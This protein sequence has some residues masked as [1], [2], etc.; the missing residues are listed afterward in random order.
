MKNIRFSRREFL[1]FS[2]ITLSGLALSGTPFSLLKGGTS[3]VAFAG[4]NPVVRIGYIPITDATPLL[5]GYAKGFFEEEGLRVERPKLIR[6]WSAISEAF[7]S[8]KLN[9][10]HLLFPITIYMRYKLGVPAKVVSWDHTNNSAITVVG[11]GKIRELT[12]LGGKK[13]AVPYWYSMHNVV[14]QEIL[15]KQTIQP[16]IGK[17]GKR[18]GKK[19]TH[20]IIM[21]PPDMP[22]ALASGAI[23]GYIVA[24]PFNAAGE[25]FAKGRIL[26]FTGDVWKNHPCCVI[27]MRE[28]HLENREWSQ[29]IMNAL[30]K[31]QLYSMHNLEEVARIL[32]RE[33]ENLIPLPEKVLRRALTVYKNEKSYIGTAIRH[34]EWNTGR[35]G[36]QPYPFPSHTR[37]MLDLFKK[38]EFE[39]DRRF[40]DRLSGDR[41]VK[42][43]INY[44]FVK[45][46]I[47]K[48]GGLEKFISRSEFVT[49]REF[50]YD[51]EVT[52]EI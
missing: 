31:A 3:S 22:T 26:R 1:K 42:D 20:L 23:D 15:R 32:S 4:D 35:I 10:V 52:F 12:D 46:S 49:S 25:I 41:V 45:N 39:G 14:L 38:A 27:T 21:N 48:V 5:I 7:I 11:N 36:F 43:L 24:E 17:R 16:T 50:G 37:L 44:D 8:G 19:E 33:G 18:I 47:Q 34:P 13:I 2:G 30:V 29:K 40:L 28:E 6:G 51:Q 9:L